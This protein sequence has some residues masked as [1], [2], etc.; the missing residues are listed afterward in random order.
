MRFLTDHLAGDR[1]FRVRSRGENL[2]KAVTQFA[3]T[4]DI[5]RQEGAIR[6]LIAEAFGRP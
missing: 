2:A 5:E 1:Y 4:A 6:A 3:L